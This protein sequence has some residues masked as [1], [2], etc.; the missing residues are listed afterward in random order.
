MSEHD[1]D[2]L[3]ELRHAEIMEGVD[4]LKKLHAQEAEQS[5]AEHGAII[6]RVDD[7]NT[8]TRAHIGSEVD[9]VRND[10][11]FLKTRMDQ[12]VKAIRRFLERHGMRDEDL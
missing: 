10:V 4:A 2:E 6:R 1:R 12:V 5:S 8:E 3:D 11:S 7:Q 9:T